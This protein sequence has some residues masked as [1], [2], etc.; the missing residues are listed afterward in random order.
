MEALKERMEE[1]H[2]KT[3]INQDL[4]MD[5]HNL[6]YHR[7]IKK[8]SYKIGDYVLCDHPRLKKGVSRGR[9]RKYYGPFIICG[10]REIKVDY[11][12]RRIG[13]K[14]GKI[15]QIYQNRLK[16]YFKHE[17]L[18]E[19]DEI[20]CTERRSLKKGYTLKTQFTPDGRDAKEN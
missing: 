15:Y 2:R 17:S 8:F 10:I 13:K 11:L 5:K 20:S 1:S 14:R 16:T 12:T 6:F 18:V 4:A 3:A 9:A 19:N 7:N